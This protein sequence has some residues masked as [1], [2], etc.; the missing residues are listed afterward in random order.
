MV[1]FW[2]FGYIYQEAFANC[3]SLEKVMVLASN[4]PFAYDNTF[5]N[6][7]IS[8]YIPEG[9]VDSYQSTS[10]WSKFSSFKTLT[11]DDIEVKVCAKPTISYENGQ[12][13]FECETEGVEFISSI[14]DSDIKDYTSASIQLSVTYTISVYATK[15]GYQNSDV[16][17]ATICW[18]D[19][20]PTGENVVVG[21]AEVRAVPVLIESDGGVLTVKG[22]AE[23]TPMNV[24]DTAGRK[25]GSATASAQATRIST[26]LRNGDIGIVRIGDKAVKVAIK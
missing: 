16:T 22:V 6:Y 24:Y 15:A 7:N 4:P 21:Q 20:T 25:V 19:V 26:T 18:L 23:G 14:K 17:R 11:G 12:L 9:S 2:D 5:S 1:I 10:P 8:L 3:S 13:K